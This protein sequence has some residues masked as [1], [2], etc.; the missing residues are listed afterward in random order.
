MPAIHVLRAKSL[1]ELESQVRGGEDLARYHEP[2]HFTFLP[3]QL[4]VFPHQPTADPPALVVSTDPRRGRAAADLEHAL[5]VY[6]WIG[7]LSE[8]EARDR[9]LWAWMAH[10][11]FADYTRARWPIPTNDA[12]KARNSILDHWFV[13]GEGRSSLRRHSIARLWWAVHLT[14]SPWERDATLAPLRTED[15]HVYTRVLLGNQDVFFHTLEREF[16]S[17]RRIL[18][19][20]LEVIRHSKRAPG[21]LVEWLAKEVNLACRYRELDLLPIKELISFLESLATL[22]GEASA[23]A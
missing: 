10:V 12:A 1:D 4:L 2:G 9:R 8:T 6:S 13:R 16:G 15:P 17:N 23:A 14:Q 20:M 3:E 21:P 22:E 11:P 19:A 18:I 7:P 5:Q